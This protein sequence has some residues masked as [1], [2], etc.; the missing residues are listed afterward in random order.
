MICGLKY[1]KITVIIITFFLQNFNFSAKIFRCL[2]VYLHKILIA[3]RSPAN[4]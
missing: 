2:Y 4:S 3:E 1:I